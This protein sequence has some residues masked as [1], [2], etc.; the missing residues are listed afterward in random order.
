MDG[1]T[2]VERQ[3]LLVFVVAVVKLPKTVWLQVENRSSSP[4]REILQAL[5]LCRRVFR[6]RMLVFA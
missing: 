5:Q 3:S 4:F 6:V 1:Q 2:I